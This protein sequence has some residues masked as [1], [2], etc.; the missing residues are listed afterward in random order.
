MS[1]PLDDVRLSG[2]HVP[3]P[4]EDFTAD[5]SELFFDLAFVVA[6][7]QLVGRLV[8]DPTLAGVA[9]TGLLFL[10]LWLPWTQFTWTVNAAATTRALRVVMLVATVASIP[11]AAAVPTAFEGGGLLFGIS[12]ATILAIGVAVML[13]AYDTG[14]AEFR[15]ALSYS[16]PNAVA[17][18]LLVAGGLVSDDARVAVWVV[19]VVVVIGGTIR[20]GSGSWVVRPGHFAER[21]GLIVIVALGEVVV[22]IALPLLESLGEGDGV[23]GR[24]VVA[25]V[26]AGVFAGL[27][28]WSYFDRAQPEFERA[29][30]GG[31][32]TERARLARDVYTYLHAPI[33]AGIVLTAAALE[34]IV[35]HPDEALPIEFR[36]ILVGG[37]VLLLGGTEAGLLR[38]SRRLPPER[39]VTIVVLV[40]LVSVSGTTNGLV[41][42]VVID[43]VFLT[44][45]VVEHRRLSSR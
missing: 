33:T 41:V 9:E 16:A 22:A 18:V 19:A 7:T 37:L 23:P 38:V 15:S 25:L 17:I 26:A 20:A 3:D 45:L 44:A 21:H 1:P 30:A 43:V 5:Q 29:C 13:V 12:V 8:D 14:S 10:L 27:L 35:L 32:T 31:D 6:F 11:V 40:V 2:F 36:W 39:I 34:E 42:L 28:W 4:D 24:S